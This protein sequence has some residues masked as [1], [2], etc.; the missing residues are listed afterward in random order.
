M[1]PKVYLET[2]FVS[3]FAARPSRDIITA[4]HQQLTQEWWERRKDNFDVFISQIVLQEARE[5]DEDA[6]KRRLEPETFS[7]CGYPKR[8]SRY[9]SSARL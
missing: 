1:K 5:G 7:E 9:M 6:I 3:Y 8:N 4:A 2:T